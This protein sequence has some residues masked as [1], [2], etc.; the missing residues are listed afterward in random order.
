[1]TYKHANSMKPQLTNPVT[2]QQAKI[3][4]QINPMAPQQA[5]TNTFQQK[6]PMPT[7]HGNIMPTCEIISKTPHQ[8][9]TVTTQQSNP[10]PHQKHS[11]APNS[12]KAKIAFMMKSKEANLESQ[13]PT[14]QF[15][16]INLSP[17]V[18]SAKTLVQ[19]TAKQVF[20]STP[21]AAMN[22][23][24]QVNP[25]SLVFKSPKLV[26]NER[27]NFGQGISGNQGDHGKGLNFLSNVA[28]KHGQSMNLSKLTS[29]NISE[30]Q[31]LAANHQV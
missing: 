17:P 11:Q 22:P 19:P 20:E 3:P 14:Q 12:L 5:S 30:N 26:N 2:A 31:K 6:N 16:S 10:M 28:Y 21:K 27:N 23:G 4:K 7:Q 15:R 18:T 24:F 25:K 9:N 8:T 13:I 29:P 1:M